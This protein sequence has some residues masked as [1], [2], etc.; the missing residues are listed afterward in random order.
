MKRRDIV[1]GLIILVL[2]AGVIYIRQ[3]TRLQ[4]EMVVPETLSTEQVF[5]EKFNIQIPD[6]VDKAE[7]K[8]VGDLGGSGIAIRKFEEGQFT[9]SILVDLPDPETGYFYEG[10]LAKGEEGED[11]YSIISTGRLR[12]AKGGWMLDFSSRTDLSDYEKVIVSLER[13]F[14]NTIEEKVLEGSF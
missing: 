5:E 3:R 4:E 10:W 13:V 2:L 7:L 14:D 12:L 6:D 9:H 8:E 11:D 1:I